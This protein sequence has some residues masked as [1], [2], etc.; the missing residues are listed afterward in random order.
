MGSRRAEP[1]DFDDP[2]GML[3]FIT[4]PL[5]LEKINYCIVGAETA[6]TGTRHFQIYIQFKNQRSGRAVLNAFNRAELYPHI[7]KARASPLKNKEYCSKEGNYAEF[8]T[9]PT[10]AHQ[11]KGNLLDMLEDYLYLDNNHAIYNGCVMTCETTKRDVVEAMMRHIM[12]D[13]D[14]LI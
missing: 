2:K 8:G 3:Q 13:N 12:M 5:G 7:E 6:S 10:G 14:Y 9:I 4:G 11:L 1:V